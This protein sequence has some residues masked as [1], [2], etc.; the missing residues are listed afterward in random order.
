MHPVGARLGGTMKRNDVGHFPWG[1]A[2]MVPINRNA[3]RYLNHSHLSGHE[4]YVSL[5]RQSGIL[6]HLCQRLQWPVR[7]FLLLSVVVFSEIADQSVFF[8][9]SSC[10]ALWNFGVLKLPGKLWLSCHRQTWHF[11]RSCQMYFLTHFSWFTLRGTSRLL[12]CQPAGL[13]NTAAVPGNHV[14]RGGDRK[15]VV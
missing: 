3:E 8:P 2:G 9:S 13:R 6:G 4:L 7:H 12:I 10:R 5:I 15:S 14:T 11:W 1:P